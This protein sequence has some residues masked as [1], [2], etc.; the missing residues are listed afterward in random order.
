MFIVYSDH[1][2]E[3]LVAWTSALNYKRGKGQVGVTVVEE[4]SEF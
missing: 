1:S 2:L 4:G 3:E